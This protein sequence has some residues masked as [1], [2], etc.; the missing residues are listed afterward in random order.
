MSDLNEVNFQ[1]NYKYLPIHLKIVLVGTVSSILGTLLPWHTTVDSFDR[2]T[3]F[4]GLNGPTIILG[5]SILILNLLSLSSIIQLS[6]NKSEEKLIIK[7]KFIESK[8]GLFNLYLNLVVLTVYLSP[9]F[10]AENLQSSF[11]LGFF[12]CLTGSIL[13]FSAPILF[14]EKKYSSSISTS[15]ENQNDVIIDED[16]QLHLDIDESEQHSFFVPNLTRKLINNV[17]TPDASNHLDSLKRQKQIEEKI[18]SKI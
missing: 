6:K 8:L 12:L 4:W 3:T 7:K 10:N 5:F 2:G 1:T 17:I 15:L 13:S 9:V 14:R 18:A 16:L 11:G